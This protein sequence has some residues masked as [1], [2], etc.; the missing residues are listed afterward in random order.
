M[1]RLH[2]VAEAALDGRLDAT[3]LRSSGPEQAL[4]DLQRISGVG[5]FFAELILI[6][7]A[8][9]PD[10]FSRTERRLH[11]AMGEGY[12]ADPGDLDGLAALAEQWRPYRSSDR[13]PVPEPR[14]EVALT[15]A[16][17]QPPAPPPR[18]P[19]GTRGSC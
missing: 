5:P 11:G 3:R 13:L 4:A 19:A 7:G 1:D 9:E 6:R 8:G 16:L 12:G 2:A 14:R 17:L 15:P 10:Y 18:T